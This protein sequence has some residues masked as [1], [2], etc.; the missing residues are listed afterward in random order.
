M[1]AIFMLTMA[2]AWALLRRLG[3]PPLMALTGVILAFSGYGLLYYREL[4]HHDAPGLLGVLLLLLAI[5][6]SKR[7][8][9]RRRRG[10]TLATLLAVSLG[11]GF[12]SLAVPGLWFL[13]EAAGILARRG[14][15]MGGVR[16]RLRAIA[17]HRAP[18][19]G[20]TRRACWPWRYFAA[21][22]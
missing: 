20:M 12:P 13:L 6:E 3:A 17:R 5:A 16:A 7:S 10:L 9:H 18:S 4:L 21:R 19:R 15:N 11:E 2:L 22:C 1:L 14:Q 8:G